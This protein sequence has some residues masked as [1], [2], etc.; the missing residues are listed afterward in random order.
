MYMQ[1]EPWDKAS[2]GQGT[3]FCEHRWGGIQNSISQCQGLNSLAAGSWGGPG[4]LEG[5][6]RAVAVVGGGEEATWGGLRA[7]ALYQLAW[8]YFHILPISTAD[9]ST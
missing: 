8:N 5:V 2:M 4:V 9:S 1:R 7:D 3:G 6:A